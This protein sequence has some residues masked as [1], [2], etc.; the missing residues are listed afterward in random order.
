[1]LRINI[2]GDDAQVMGILYALGAHA[3]A[4]LG[5]ASVPAAPPVAPPVA[6]AQKP[7]PTTQTEAMPPAWANGYEVAMSVVQAWQQDWDAPADHQPD[8][9]EILGKFIGSPTS[10]AA[11]QMFLRTTPDPW[12]YAGATPLQAS[13]IAQVGSALQL[14]PPPS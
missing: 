9:Q 1:M 14:L 6:P 7:L 5:A 11:L 13:H 10:L 12:V 8:R 3:Y 4:A 2:E